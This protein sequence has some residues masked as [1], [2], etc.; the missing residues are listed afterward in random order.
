MGETIESRVRVKRARK[1]KRRRERDRERGGGS[2][3]TFEKC[4]FRSGTTPSH[5]T[6]LRNY[7]LF[8]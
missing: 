6:V 4:P 7:G 2:N 8:R 5:K 3:L 1:K